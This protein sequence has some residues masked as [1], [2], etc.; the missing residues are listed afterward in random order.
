MH[1]R[2]I[3]QRPPFSIL[4]AEA[5]S[6]HIHMC[7]QVYNTQFTGFSQQTVHSSF[8]SSVRVMF[9][10]G[11]LLTFTGEVG[12]DVAFDLT[13]AVLGL[14]TDLSDVAWVLGTLKL[15]STKGCN[16]GGKLS[17]S[18]ARSRWWKDG[19]GKATLR[20]LYPDAEWERIISE[21]G[22]GDVRAVVP[23]RQITV[24]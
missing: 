4:T 23:W 14:A 22:P 3:G 24:I 8:A 1:W 15:R 13:G 6:K 21:D 9:S 7:P 20:L 2:Q 10:S 12:R 16:G 11:L 18:D 5:H 17:T 19:W